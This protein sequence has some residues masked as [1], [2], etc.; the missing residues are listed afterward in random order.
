MLQSEFEPISDMRA[1]AVYRREL[2]GNLVRRFALEVQG[3][4]NVS[5][6]TLALEVRP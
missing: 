3:E 6:D 2:L 5:I 1:S 4:A